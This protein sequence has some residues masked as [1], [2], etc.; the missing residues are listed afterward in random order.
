MLLDPRIVKMAQVLV[1]YSLGVQ[2][3][4]LVTVSATPSALPLVQAV[5]REVIMAGAHP[6]V[7]L[8]APGVREI[9]LQHGNDDQLTKV[10]PYQMLMVEQSDAILRIKGEDN[11]RSTSN[12]DPARQGLYQ[13][14]SQP[15]GAAFM[16]RIMDNRPHCLTLYPTNAYAQD[17]E[18]SL[19][20]W[21]DFVFRACLLDGD[22]DPVARWLQVSREQQHIVDW[23]E[24]KKSVH[25]EAPGTDLR[26]SIEGRN[27]VN[28]DGKRNFPS[29]EV[30]TS[31]VEESV[32][33][34]IFFSYPAS[35]NGRTVQGVRLSF[36]KGVVTE[37]SA[38]AGED[39][40]AAMLSLDE[41]AKR[42]GEFA[43]GT[44]KG[45]TRITRNVLFDEKIAGTIHCALGN[46]YPNA[47]G[48]NKSA[49]HWDI[50]TDMREGR[51][52]VDGQTLY[53]NG[54][55]VI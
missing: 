13:K 42:M 54:A 39:Y 17:A 37:Y 6:F 8:E 50:V 27:F 51:I 7:L 31:P 22:D 1:G 33:G 25:V 19:T 14:G 32:E 2:K 11:T 29:G 40:L 12:V 36:E 15:V 38:E 18:M 41:G 23:L 5:C 43:I 46:G 47:G 45:V 9:L 55:F 44:N 4:W 30:F 16:Q 3:G 28:S 34:T 53:E 21:E 48:K 20:E 52:V 24:G 10:D 26:M 49:I 35:H